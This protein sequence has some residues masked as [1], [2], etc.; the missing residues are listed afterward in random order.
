MA[1]REGLDP[2]DPAVIAAID[3]CPMGIVARDLSH[4]TAAGPARTRQ[5]IRTT[6]LFVHQQSGDWS[7][8]GYSTGRRATMTEDRSSPPKWTEFRWDDL[9]HWA[10]VLTALAVVAPNQAR[11]CL[12]ISDLA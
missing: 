8:D 7:E 2:D 9:P 3:L 5:S 11:A 6:D 1:Q 4:R 10:R 12:R